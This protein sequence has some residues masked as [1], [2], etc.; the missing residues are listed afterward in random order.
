MAGPAKNMALAWKLIGQG[1]KIEAP[2]PTGKYL[3]CDHRVTSD[4]S[5][6]GSNPMWELCNDSSALRGDF[7]VEESTDIIDTVPSTT[8]PSTQATNEAKAKKEKAAKDAKKKKKK[9]KYA[10]GGPR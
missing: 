8:D 6:L 10:H 4:K 1:L 5:P 9:D 3:G 7:P 2:T